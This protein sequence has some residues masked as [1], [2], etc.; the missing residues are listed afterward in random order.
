MKAFG[1]LFL[2]VALFAA[3]EKPKEVDLPQLTDAQVADWLQARSDIMD[4]KQQLEEATS[5]ANDKGKVLVDI[6][7]KGGRQVVRDPGTSK[8]H[9]SVPPMVTPVK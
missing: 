4:F 1:L 5:R 9:C 3:D 6:C 2:G 7:N 8:W